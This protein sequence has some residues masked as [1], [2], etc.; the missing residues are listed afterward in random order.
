MVLSVP[1]NLTEA[2]RSWRRL[3]AGGLLTI[4]P[5]GHIHVVFMETKDAKFQWLSAAIRFREIGSDR[6]F[7]VVLGVYNYV[8]WCDLTVDR[9]SHTNSQLLGVNLLPVARFSSG[10]QYSKYSFLPWATT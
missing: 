4:N 2:R 7:V 10:L 5:G 6:E 3:L 9:F 1:Q 8:P